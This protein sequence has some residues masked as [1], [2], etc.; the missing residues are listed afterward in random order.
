VIH[1]KFDFIKKP[2]DRDRKESKLARETGLCLRLLLLLCDPPPPPLGMLYVLLV[3]SCKPRGPQPLSPYYQPARAPPRD[4]MRLLSRHCCTD[5]IHRAESGFQVQFEFQRLLP[6]F[7]SLCEDPHPMPLS[8]LPWVGNSVATAYRA[9]HSASAVIPVGEESWLV[10]H[11]K[12]A[13]PPPCHA[14]S[15]FPP[16]IWDRRPGVLLSY[17]Y[18]SRMS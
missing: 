9:H 12:T 6:F 16:H 4:S 17:L 18:M 3:R 5:P 10:E 7:L 8:V 13:S 2:N 14:S 15:A 11:D 1:A